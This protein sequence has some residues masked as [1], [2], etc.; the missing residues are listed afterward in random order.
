MG[1]DFTLGFSFSPE[2]GVGKVVNIC[3]DGLRTKT[4]VVVSNTE[5][6]GFF[7]G[8]IDRVGVAGG[9]I[10]TVWLNIDLDTGFTFSCNW[11]CLDG[12]PFNPVDTVIGGRKTKV[13]C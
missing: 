13:C 3:A 2:I 4:G 8:E 11:L 7:V 12:E 1:V 5:D 6:A 9:G 10:E